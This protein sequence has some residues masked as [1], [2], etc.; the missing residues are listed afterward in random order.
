MTVVL[1]GGSHSRLSQSGP[2]LSVV[3]FLSFFAFC[4]I[5]SSL[6]DIS[7]LHG[8]QPKPRLICFS[9]QNQAFVFFS[10]LPVDCYRTTVFYSLV[11]KHTTHYT[12]TMVERKRQHI[13]TLGGNV[14]L[15]WTTEIC[16]YDTTGG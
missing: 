3:L 15:P 16:T 7:E 1:R 5:V 4:F 8:R 11:G 14:W 9:T 10:L 2:H 6:S 12:Q 13:K